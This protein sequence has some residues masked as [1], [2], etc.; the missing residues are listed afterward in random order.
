LKFIE[1]LALRDTYM[2]SS[3]GFVLV[4][5]LSK[6]RTLADV[7]T[8][9][10][11]ISQVKDVDSFPIGTYFKFFKFFLILNETQKYL[12]EINVIWLAKEK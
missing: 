10:K 7:D 3:D 11:K 5:D 1:Y 2:R 12:L 9:I 8:F 6:K 4:F